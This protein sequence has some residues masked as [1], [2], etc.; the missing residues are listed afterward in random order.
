MEIRRPYLVRGNQAAKELHFRIVSS[1]NFSKT[2]HTG[3]WSRPKTKE[4]TQKLVPKGIQQIFQNVAL[5]GQISEIIEKL[6]LK[7]TQKIF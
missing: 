4:F 6:V 7:G 2:V 1:L 5:K 3:I